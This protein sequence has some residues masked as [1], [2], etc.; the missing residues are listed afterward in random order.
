MENK[1]FMKEDFVRN[2]DNEYELQFKVSE[3]GEGSN[4]I[5]ERL[6]EKNEYETVQ[7][8]IRRFDDFVFIVWD[9]PFDGRIFFDN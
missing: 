8:Q 7:V 4:L 6:N 1:I 2:K 3:I 9:K 5:T